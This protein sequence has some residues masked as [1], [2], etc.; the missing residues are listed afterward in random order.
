MALGCL[1]WSCKKL[2]ARAVVGV[3][4]VT[5][6][7]GCLLALTDTRPCAQL[8]SSAKDGRARLSLLLRTNYPSIS[9][10]KDG[11]DVCKI[12]IH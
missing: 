11:V 6:A 12:S 7:L 10:G 3:Q 1:C 4:D 2:A 9:L 5:L 8:S